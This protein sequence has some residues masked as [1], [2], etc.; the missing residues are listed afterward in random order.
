METVNSRHFFQTTQ[1][2]IFLISYQKFN[3]FLEAT[4]SYL[5]C[6]SILKSTSKTVSAVA[7]ITPTDFARTPLPFYKEQKS[8]TSEISYIVMKQ[9]T[10]LW[11]YFKCD[12]NISQILYNTFPVTS[13]KHI[14]HFILRLQ[15]NNIHK[16]CTFKSHFCIV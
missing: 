2:L 7:S 16:K 15:D 3:T 6:R 10:N 4:Y 12:R 13:W 8:N 1:T 11:Y 9:S 5:F 14:S